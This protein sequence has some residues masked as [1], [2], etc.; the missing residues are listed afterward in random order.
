MNV[1]KQLPEIGVLLHP[2]G[3]IAILKEM[4]HSAMAAVVRQGIPGEEPPHDPR[5]AG[6]AAPEQEMGMVG[7]ERPRIDGGPCGDG[8]LAQSPEKGLAVLAIRH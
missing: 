6:G 2:D 7:E 4:P 1:P 5:Q 8:D 3:F